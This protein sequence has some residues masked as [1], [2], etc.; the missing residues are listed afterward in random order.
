MKVD[1]EGTDLERC[2]AKSQGLFQSMEPGADIRVKVGKALPPLPAG[3]S[4]GVMFAFAVLREAKRLAVDED[5]M[6]TV[7]ID[8][9]GDT[10]TMMISPVHPKAKERYRETLAG[11]GDPSSQFVLGFARE[12]CKGRIDVKDMGDASTLFVTLNRE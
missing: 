8:A 12:A 3:Q 9:E 10:V 4:E 11:G 5:Q 2:F 6:P 7:R 1:E